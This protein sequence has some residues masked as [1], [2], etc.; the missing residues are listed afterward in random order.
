M[1]SP[2]KTSLSVQGEATEMHPVVRDEA[3][4]VAYEAI[5][6]ACVH[7]K[8]SDLAVELKYAQ[9]LSISVSDNG[10]GIP[11]PLI[12]QGRN[13]HYGLQGMRERAERIGG[14]LKVTSSPNSGTKVTLVIPGRIVFLRSDKSAI[15]RIT[16][17]FRGTR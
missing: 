2:M 7:S 3:Y 9:D 14:K 5:R 12:D 17:L 15:E 13:G 1:F 6:N 8:A 11:Q 10:V 16:S 4:R